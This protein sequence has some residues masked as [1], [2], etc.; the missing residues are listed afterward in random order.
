MLNG[1][2]RWVCGFALGIGL[3]AACSSSDSSQPAGAGASASGAGG[4]SNDA[5]TTGGSAGSAGS[6]TGGSATGGSSAGGSSGAAEDAA[7]GDG[8]AGCSVLGPNAPLH[9]ADNGGSVVGG[10]WPPAAVGFNLADVSSADEVDALPSGVSALIWVGLCD[11]ADSAFIAAVQP[12]VGKSK[13]FGFYLFDEPDPTGQYNT[14]CSAA[15]FKAESD[16]IHSNIPG[17]KTF[18]V[19]MN[20]GSSAK[21]SFANTYNPTNSGIDLYGVDPYPCRVEFSGCDYSMIAPAVAAAVDS[22]IPL[23]AIVPVYQTFG[24]GGYTTD[25]GGSYQLPTADQEKQLLTTW[26]AAAPSPAFDMVYS[27]GTQNG[28]EALVGSTEL[29]QVLSVHNAG[30]GP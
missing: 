30:C 4:S 7:V 19:M 10:N 20:M 1:T 12:F 16:W 9:F 25:T 27:W 6:S 22:G 28:D 11:G 15:N 13:V 21:P 17:A 5:S 2:C 18:I 24:G 3:V 23:E 26:A 29:Q 8:S 14:K